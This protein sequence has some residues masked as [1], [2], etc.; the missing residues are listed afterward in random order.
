MQ[1]T[2]IRIIMNYHH[3]IKEVKAMNANRV[4][5]Y[6]YNG[7]SVYDVTGDAWEVYPDELGNVR[8]LP[9][10]FAEFGAE[11]YNRAGFCYP[12]LR[13]GETVLVV[14]IPYVPTFDVVFDG[15]GRDRKGWSCAYNRCLDYIRDYNGTDESHFANYGGGTVSVVCNETGE[16]VYR[17]AVNPVVETADERDM[18][19]FNRWYA[20]ARRRCIEA[21]VPSYD[22]ED[23]ICVMIENERWTVGEAYSKLEALR[24]AETCCFAD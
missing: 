17:E 7:T 4:Q 8:E 16:T 24:R 12:P 13:E 5:I 1:K 3:T 20:T 9:C 14:A 21:G 11:A 19:E 18:R 10:E 15:N 2:L 23:T 22:V 6:V